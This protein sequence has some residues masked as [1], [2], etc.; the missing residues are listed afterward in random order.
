[1]TP[2]DPLRQPALVVDLSNNNERQVPA[3]A[4][5][6]VTQHVH[7]LYLKATEGANFV[8]RDYGRW[9]ALA[10]NAG[11][12]VGAYHFAR[13]GHNPGDHG[14]EQEAKHF[15]G[16]IG[17]LG[18]RDLKP[19]LDLEVEEISTVTA[20]AR[21]FCQTVHQALGR[22]FYSYPYYIEHLHAE[23]PIGDGLWLASFGRN[24]GKEHPYVA[25]KPWH[26]VQLH[27]FSSRATVAGLVGTVDLSMAHNG[28]GPL[29]A[30]PWTH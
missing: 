1:V 10:H 27:Q 28:L 6:R 24:D 11:I 18:D 23:T 14:A 7:G 22:Y 4:F 3:D 5:Q 25:P 30:H 8:D 16:V 19:A 9:R 20:W 21:R 15:L 29:L 13:P 17:E 2:P 12:Y 26:K